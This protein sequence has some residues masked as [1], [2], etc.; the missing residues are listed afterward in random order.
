MGCGVGAGY[1]F[2]RAIPANWVS[3]AVR[4]AAKVQRMESREVRYEV[5]PFA[6]AE[7]EA[8]RVVPPLTLTVTCS[9]KH[10]PDHTVD[11]ARRLRAL[12]HRVIVH[13]AARMVSSREHLDQLLERMAAGGIAD[14]FLVGGD[15]AEPVGPYPSAVS[16]LAELSGHELAPRTI[17][18]PAY[19]EGHPLIAPAVLRADLLEKGHLADY[20]TT[21]MCFDPNVLLTWLREMRS[22]GVSLPAY[23]GVPG[24]VDR[25]RLLEVSLRVG[26]GTSISFVRKQHGVRHLF[27]GGG[28]VAAHLYAAIAPEI[29]ESLGVA[30]VHFFTF[31]R[32]VETVRF[33]DER[34][35]EESFRSRLADRGSASIT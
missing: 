34:S 13:V 31:N 9:P 8:A 28:S 32:L 16:L 21:Q 12:G 17:G 30:G 6:S 20:M 26:V 7:P 1:P 18:V 27:G 19:P 4:L 14:V 2:G 10:G 25:R 35:G 33:V 24:A 3:R 23:V 15:A 29:R 5:L 22:A 11:V